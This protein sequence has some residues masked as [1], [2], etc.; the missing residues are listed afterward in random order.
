IRNNRARH[1]SECFIDRFCNHASNNPLER[2]E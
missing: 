2:N 1:N